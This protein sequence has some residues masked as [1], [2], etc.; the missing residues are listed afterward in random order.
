MLIS[1]WIATSSS[2]PALKRPPTL[3]VHALG[4]LAEHDE[5]D[6]LPAAILQRAQA[7]VEQ[8]HRAVVHVEIEL[9]ARA[10]KNVARVAV[11]GDARIAQRADEDRLELVAQHLVAVGRQRLAGLQVVIGAPRQ[12]LEIEPA[13][14]HL[15]GRLQHL[16]RFGGDVLA[17]SVAGNDRNTHFFWPMARP[18]MISNDCSNLGR[19]S[20]Q[21]ST[22]LA[23]AGS[24]LEIMHFTTIIMC[25]RPTFG[26][27]RRW[28][29]SPKVRM[30]PDSRSSCFF[31]VCR[32]LSK[33]GK[34]M[35]ARPFATL[36]LIGCAGCSRVGAGTARFD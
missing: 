16:D 30:T 7:I 14:E 1:S 24:T 26:P 23:R 29:T 2:V 12:V 3:D 5:V 17:D 18:P 34:V 20:R 21:H 28:T 36:L 22:Q 11:V 6:V 35:F 32:C 27:I 9:E 4:V 15:A 33:G 19:K 31:P 10:Q 8:A 25:I 13:S